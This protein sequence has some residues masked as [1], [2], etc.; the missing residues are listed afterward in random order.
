V[1]PVSATVW[2]LSAAAVSDLA[3]GALKRKKR[4]GRHRRLLRLLMP[5]GTGVDRAGP[6]SR[7]RNPVRVDHVLRRAAINFHH[8]R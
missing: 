8:H 7:N 6:L 2:R 4:F 3:K 5:S 1:V